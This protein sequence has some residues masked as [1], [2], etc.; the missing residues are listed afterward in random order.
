MRL[1][2]CPAT[3]FLPG[4]M[5]PPLYY[6]LLTAVA[7][8]VLVHYFSLASPVAALICSMGT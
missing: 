6:P 3:E 1:K 4:D 8:Y 2:A 7:Y 5:T